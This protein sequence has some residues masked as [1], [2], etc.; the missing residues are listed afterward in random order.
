LGVLAGQQ[1]EVTAI[2]RAIPEERASFRYQAGKWS[3][4]EL[5]GH[6]T[7]SERVFSYRALFFA[8]GGKAE[9]PPFDQDEFVAHAAAERVAL[10]GLVDQF[11][12]L[13]QSNVLLFRQLPPDAWMRSG[14]ASGVRVSVRGLAYVTAGHVR[15]HMRVLRD[16]YG[17]P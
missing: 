1:R 17:L 13:R 4:R 11:E 12:A 9:L 6:I 8:R 14:I 3:I 10:S 15:H 7:D 16:R 2:L 5:V